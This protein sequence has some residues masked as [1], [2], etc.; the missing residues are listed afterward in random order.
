MFGEHL[1]RIR[2]SVGSKQEDLAKFLNISTQSVSKWEKGLSLPS[3]DML[4]KIAEFY[5]CT[6]NSFFSEYELTIFEKI[7]ENAPS[8]DDII[9]LLVTMIPAD[10][11]SVSN[12]SD[13]EYVCSTDSIPTEALF[14][15]QVYNI[16]SNN[17]T[18]SCALI[19]KKLGVGYALAARI[20]D[21]V[22]GLG[23]VKQNKETLLY[24]IDKNKIVLLEPYL[25]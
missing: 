8:Q 21:A 3:I 11:I 12:D 10:K 17:A 1:R 4:P 5:N 23:I 20:I 22:S 2:L 6:I 16:L 14:L 9:K 25:K 13:E 18:V 7:N 15:P 19:Q 24:E